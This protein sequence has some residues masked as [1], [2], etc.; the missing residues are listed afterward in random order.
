VV[1]EV[2]AFSSILAHLGT[3]SNG[4]SP[5]HISV[6]ILKAQHGILVLGHFASERSFL[7]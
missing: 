3:C 5:Q 7:S 2:R 4:K 1:A 6:E